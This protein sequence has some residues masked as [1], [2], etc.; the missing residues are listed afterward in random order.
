[1][2]SASRGDG[3]RGTWLMFYLLVSIK[4]LYFVFYYRAVQ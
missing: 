4:S 3:A 2:G 1:M